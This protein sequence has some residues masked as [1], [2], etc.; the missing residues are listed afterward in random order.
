MSNYFLR[1]GVRCDLSIKNSADGICYLFI[2]FLRE[3]LGSLSEPKFMYANTPMF[4]ITNA[5]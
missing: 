4:L 5:R 1:H 3:L 2:Y